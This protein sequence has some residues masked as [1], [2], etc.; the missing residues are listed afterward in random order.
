MWR[1][2]SFFVSS[3]GIALQIDMDPQNLDVWPYPDRGFLSGSMFR[4]GR[5]D[6]G[7]LTSPKRRSHKYKGVVGSC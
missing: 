7:C 6:P 3:L 5:V 2:G 1:M 4:S